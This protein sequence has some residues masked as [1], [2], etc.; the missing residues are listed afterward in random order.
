[1]TFVKTKDSDYP[2]TFLHRLGFRNT[3]NSWRHKRRR[4]L[5]SRAKQQNLTRPRYCEIWGSH[6]GY[7]KDVF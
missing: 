6:S 5:R 3:G 7:V 1:M 4:L 2:L